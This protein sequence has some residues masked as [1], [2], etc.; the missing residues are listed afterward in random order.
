LRHKNAGGVRVQRGADDGAGGAARAREW[1]AIAPRFNDYFV[2]SLPG[3]S[4]GGL[5]LFIPWRMAAEESGG[6]NFGFGSACYFSDITVR[7]DEALFGVQA[8]VATDWEKLNV[9]TLRDESPNSLR[10]RYHHRDCQE[11]ERDQIPCAIVG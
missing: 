11:S 5:M 3:I 10:R 7:G 6:A 4:A 2:L 9:E 8:N 1:C